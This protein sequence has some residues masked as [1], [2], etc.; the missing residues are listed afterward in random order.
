MPLFASSRNR[1]DCCACFVTTY[2]P[3]VRLSTIPAILVYPSRVSYGPNFGN[4][5]EGLAP[6]FKVKLASD[7]IELKYFACHSDV[8][9][10][11][12]TKY[13]SR[14][15]ITDSIIARCINHRLISCPNRRMRCMN[16]CHHLRGES[17]P[18]TFSPVIRDVIH[19]S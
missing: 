5:V 11:R 12:Y 10:S 4:Q 17:I 6:S 18:T 19:R 15:V 8:V 13:P 1:G 14:R 2:P 3:L 9:H 16:L 7:A